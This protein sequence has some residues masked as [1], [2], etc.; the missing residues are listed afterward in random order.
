MKNKIN[1]QWFYAAGVRAIRTMAQVA[2]GMITLGA[3]GSDIDWVNMIS[4]SLVAGIYS[5]LTSIATNLPELACTTPAPTDGTLQIDTSDPVK[6]SYV[7]QVSTPLEDLNNKNTV[8]F[9]VES[10]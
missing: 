6:D 1:L 2:L 4:V 9:K 8:I 5:I 10:K 7:L 3:A